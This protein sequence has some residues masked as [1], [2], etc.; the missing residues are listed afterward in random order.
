MQ[1]K[2]KNQ[3]EI[4]DGRRRRKEKVETISTSRSPGS[5]AIHPLA[6]PHA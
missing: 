1:S 5:R 2:E 6:S 4:Q 3:G